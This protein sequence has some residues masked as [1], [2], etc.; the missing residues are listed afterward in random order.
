LSRVKVAF[1]AAN[2]LDAN[3]RAAPIIKVFETVVNFMAAPFSSPQ[4]VQLGRPV[5]TISV[6]K[7]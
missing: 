2:A 4:G 3:S 6:E 7:T 5:L 1:V